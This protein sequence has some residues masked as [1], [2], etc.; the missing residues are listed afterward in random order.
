MTN[1]QKLEVLM[2]LFYNKEKKILD[3]SYLDCKDM[4]IDLSY[5]KANGIWNDHQIAKYGIINGKQQ[6]GYIL[7][8]TQ[9]ANTIYND[10]Q[11]ANG[12]WNNNQIAKNIRNHDQ[13][14]TNKETN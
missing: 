10:Y 3:L 1:K 7:N 2:K 9:K 8:D 6:A 5:I 13:R 12:I 11:E 4:S 14:E